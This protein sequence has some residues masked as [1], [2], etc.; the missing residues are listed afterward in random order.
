MA[1]NTTGDAPPAAGTE[2]SKAISGFWRG[3]FAAISL[4]FVVAAGARVAEWVAAHPLPRAVTNLATTP[5]FSVLDIAGGVV[6]L[7]FLWLVL[8][9]LAFGPGV[10]P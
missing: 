3:F 2:R 10:G 4:L 6:G 7:F 9:T 1:D 5:M 8:Y